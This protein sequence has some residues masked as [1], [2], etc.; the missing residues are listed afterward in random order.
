[1]WLARYAR[2]QAA[3]ANDVSWVRSQSAPSIDRS[4]ADRSPDAPRTPAYTRWRPRPRASDGGRRDADVPTGRHERPSTARDDR[5]GRRR[6]RR[7][8]TRH[9]YTQGP[10]AAPA[11]P[12]AHGGSGARHRADDRARRVLHRHPPADRGAARRGRR[13]LA[14]GDGG[15]RRRLPCD[16]GPDRR[17]RRLHRGGH[18]GR[19]RSLGRPARARAPPTR[20]VSVP[21][22]RNRSTAPAASWDPSARSAGRGGGARSARRFR[23]SRDPALRAQRRKALRREGAFST[24]RWRP[25]TDRCGSWRSALIPAARSAET[26]QPALPPSAEG[27]G[28]RPSTVTRPVMRPVRAGRLRDRAAEN[29]KVSGAPY[30]SSGAAVPPAA[31]AAT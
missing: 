30:G 6:A 2:P 22:S 3:H 8:A 11:P 15:P 21:M 1:M 18:G 14:A 17:C 31:S 9:G 20:E 29:R 10:G 27:P 23:R 16:G 12:V 7:A 5:A 24:T 19:A 25:W 4:L 26:G 13:R 28:R